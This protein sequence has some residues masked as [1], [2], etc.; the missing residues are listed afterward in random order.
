MAHVDQRR[1]KQS[2]TRA[3][4]PPKGVFCLGAYRG[5]VFE[6]ENRANQA[7]CWGRSGKTEIE[8]ESLGC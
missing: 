5:K 4:D 8:N 2:K 7:R 6:E 3:I 1:R